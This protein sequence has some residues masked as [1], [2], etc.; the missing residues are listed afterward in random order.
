[1]VSI[2]YDTGALL[3][4]FGKLFPSTGQ[5]SPNPRS[6]LARPREANGGKVIGGLIKVFFEEC[7]V[8]HTLCQLQG[9]TEGLT[10]WRRRFFIQGGDP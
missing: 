9:M 4:V 5:F 3:V 2:G 7:S 6:L 1:M 8:W 10:L